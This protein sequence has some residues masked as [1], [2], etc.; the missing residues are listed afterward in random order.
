MDDG[1]W[2]IYS[3]AAAAVLAVLAVF[4]ASAGLRDV[5]KTAAARVFETAF[6]RGLVMEYA[7]Q[8]RADIEDIMVNQQ[9]VKVTSAAKANPEKAGLLSVIRRTAVASVD[10][11]T[12]VDC[13]PKTAIRCRDTATGAE[14]QVRPAVRDLKQ[15]S[16][17]SEE[18]SAR[19]RPRSSSNGSPATGRARRR[20]TV[21]LSRCSRPRRARNGKCR[22][23]RP[24]RDKY[25]GASNGRSSNGAQFTTIDSVGRLRR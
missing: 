22:N 13:P 1:E 11:G 6:A 10:G 23:G 18:A 20:Q 25:P 12:R 21:G 5:R 4:C 24:V 19:N 17:P 2:V 16:A 3:D 9:D 8:Q 7:V 14:A 15:P